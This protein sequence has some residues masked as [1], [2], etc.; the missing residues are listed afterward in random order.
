MAGEIEAKKKEEES[1]AKR[2]MY[3]PPITLPSHHPSAAIKH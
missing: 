1:K 3:A 2:E